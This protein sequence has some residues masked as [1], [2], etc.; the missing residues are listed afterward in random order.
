MKD[1]VSIMEEEN[2]FKAHHE[3][4]IEILKDIMFYRNTESVEHVQYVQEYTRIIARQYAKLYPRSKMTAHKIDLIVQAAQMHDVGKITMPDAILTRPGQL[5]RSEMELLK[6][7]TINGSRIM[8]VMS[9]FQGKDY[10]RI[11]YNVCLY[12]HEK[13]DGTGYPYG[14]KKDKIPIE[15]Q[16]VALADMYDA[17][18]NE[19]M[20]N[21]V[22][23]KEKA[24]YMLMNGICGELSP[25][26]KECLQEAKESL[27]EVCIR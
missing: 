13:Y 9:E 27:E 8:K 11:C 12:H 4:L 7:H 5:S 3:H 14:L 18:V 23:S 24:F 21:E 17:L 25:R 22:Y 1:T 15:A 2:Q 26:M 10:S 16:I 19:K 20:N 6:E